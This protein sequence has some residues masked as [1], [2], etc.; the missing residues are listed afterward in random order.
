FHHGVERE[1]VRPDA[2]DLGDRLAVADELE[3][4]RGDQSDRFG[5]IELQP[6]RAS[7]SRELASADDEKLFDFA[8][9]QAHGNTSLVTVVAL[10]TPRVAV[11]V[12]AAGLPESGLIVVHESQLSHPLSALPEVEV[13]HEE[14][15]WA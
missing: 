12:I 5:V 14:S 11:V 4:L 15:R 8:R 10:L 3:D 2:H 7:F 1:D 6:A 9:S 13:R